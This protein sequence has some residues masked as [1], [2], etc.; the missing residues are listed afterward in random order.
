VSP[1][2]IGGH[3]NRHRAREPAAGRHPHGP[4]YEP[5]ALQ[6]E[7]RA[8][9]TAQEFTRIGDTAV[10]IVDFY[11]RVDADAATNLAREQGLLPP[12]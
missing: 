3:A 7:E 4:A 12:G 1:R 11:D 2:P 10:K 9:A 6:A 8:G 5:R